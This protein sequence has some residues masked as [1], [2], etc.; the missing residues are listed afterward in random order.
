MEQK[1]VGV[2]VCV[3]VVH[4][5]TVW[6]WVYLP[7]SS[8]DPHT[9]TH[10][11]AGKCRSSQHVGQGTACNKLGKKRSAHA[12]L[13]QQICALL[14][15]GRTKG[16]KGIRQ[17]TPG[18]W[19]RWCILKDWLVWSYDW[20]GLKLTWIACL[21]CTPLVR[22]FQAIKESS[23]MMAAWILIAKFSLPPNPGKA[24]AW[25]TWNRTAKVCPPL[26]I[27]KMCFET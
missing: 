18:A 11:H 7:C 27:M 3:R 26:C 8:A 4:V 2:R 10:T 23:F 22:V 13:R 24:C 5:C 25:R 6:S 9:C 17:L 14:L 21:P 12:A 20:E 1:L 15:R 19:L 16:R